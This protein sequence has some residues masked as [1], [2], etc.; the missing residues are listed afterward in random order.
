MLIEKVKCE[1]IVLNIVAEE[2]CI[3]YPRFKWYSGFLNVKQIETID[4]SRAGYTRA[5]GTRARTRR[6]RACLRLNAAPRSPCTPDFSRLASRPTPRGAESDTPAHACLFVWLV[7][8]YVCRYLV[9]FLTASLGVSLSPP[10]HSHRRYFA[11]SIIVCFKLN[12]M[13]K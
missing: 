1:L 9:L 5:T 10:S 13:V 7:A 6:V 8:S 4:A 2:I 11:L 12:F 3:F